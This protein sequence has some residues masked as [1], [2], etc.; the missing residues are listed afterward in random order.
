MPLVVRIFESVVS[1][2][3]TFFRDILSGL[4][5]GQQNFVFCLCGLYRDFK[6]DLNP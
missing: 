1:L 4:E 2:K 3:A 6:M 5:K